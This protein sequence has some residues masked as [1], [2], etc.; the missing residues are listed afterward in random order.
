MTHIRFFIEREGLCLSLAGH[1][2]II[3]RGRSDRRGKVK[4][5]AYVRNCRLYAGSKRN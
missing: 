5:A 1:S 4:E 2:S 3:A